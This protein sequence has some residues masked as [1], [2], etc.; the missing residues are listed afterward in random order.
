MEPWTVNQQNYITVVYPLAAT[1]EAYYARANESYTQVSGSF[2]DS[3]DG[4]YYISHTFTAVGS[5]TVMIVDPE[6]PDNTVTS[7]IDVI[8]VFVN[9]GMT[10][11]QESKLDAIPTTDNVAD[12]APVLSAI[13]ALN[14]ITA[15]DVEAALINEADGQTMVNAIVN[16]IGNTN[17]DETALVAAVRADLERLG[18]MLASVPTPS[19][20]WAH[21]DRTLSTAS[22]MTAAQELKLDAIPSNP[23]LATDTRLDTLLADSGP[24]ILQDKVDIANMSRDMIF[25]TQKAIG[26]GDDQTYTPST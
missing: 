9:A 11:A 16:A 19:E 12:L 22:G 15:A 17:V 26:N 13:A 24:I 21:N 5:Y 3:G 23:L 20:T 8:A 14:N 2:T 18:G 25:K 10:V 4:R 7:Q 6:E 1:L